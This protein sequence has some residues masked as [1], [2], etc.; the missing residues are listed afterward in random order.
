MNHYMECRYCGKEVPLRMRL[1]GETSFCR[2]AHRK[3]YHEEHSRIGLERLLAEVSSNDQDARAGPEPEQQDEARTEQRQHVAAVDTS[4]S[5]PSEEAP[6]QPVA[7]TSEQDLELWL[8]PPFEF[9]PQPLFR[10]L[11]RLRFEPAGY[12]AVQPE[13]S[14]TA[15]TRQAAEEELAAA[16]EA[17]PEL[18][19]PR[20]S[21]PAPAIARPASKTE[22]HFSTPGI[23]TSSKGRGR[24]PAALKIAGVTVLAATI[25]GIG[26]FGFYDKRESP[27]AGEVA[28]PAAEQSVADNG[29]WI[30]H[31]AEGPDGDVV[32]LFGPSQEWSDYLVESNMHKSQ[33]VTWAFRAVN[34]D[35]YYAMKLSA[36][37]PG[38]LNLARYAVIDGQPTGW[39]EAVVVLPA[40]VGDSFGVR[41]EV[42]G[43]QFTLSLDGRPAADWADERLPRG[44]FGV[45]AKNADLAR[46][47][48]T[49]VTQLASRSVIAPPPTGMSEALARSAPI[50]ITRAD[51]VPADG[52]IAEQ[53]TTSP[54]P[55]S[56]ITTARADQAPAGRDSE[57]LN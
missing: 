4:G 13:H 57:E 39:V 27:P 51:Q 43:S 19:Q 46:A 40:P 1:T 14:V 35:N 38:E 3:F 15:E 55:G 32:V 22:F 23:D 36:G 28:Q 18:D 42:R 26:Y 12:S 6:T 5:H 2:P 54:P 7:D 25:G 49:K 21:A 56:P 16:A 30:R 10:E 50:T 9:S 47:R 37:A 33:D 11:T 29:E 8:C 20:D 45:I 53:S 34:A 48:S 24:A 31:W 17:E 44:G 52:G 41:L